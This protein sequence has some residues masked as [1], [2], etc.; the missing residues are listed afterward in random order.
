[1]SRYRGVVLD[2]RGQASIGFRHKGG[3]VTFETEVG[4]RDLI[5]R[6]TDSRALAMRIKPTSVG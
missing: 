1:M 4:Y 3:E 5:F 2:G 6:T